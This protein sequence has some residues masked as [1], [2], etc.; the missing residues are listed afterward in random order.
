MGGGG[1]EE[2]VPPAEFISGILKER[3]RAHEKFGKGRR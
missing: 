3:E 1:M 2:K